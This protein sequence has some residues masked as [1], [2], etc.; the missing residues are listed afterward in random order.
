MPVCLACST[1]MFPGVCLKAP[2][3][4]LPSRAGF[5][6]LS[7]GLFQEH[8]L[9]YHLLH[10]RFPSG[11]CFPRNSACSV[12]L[13]LHISF[14]LSVPQQ[15]PWNRWSLIAA[16]S[17][18]NHVYSVPAWTFHG[19]G[20]VWS[21]NHHSNNPGIKSHFPT[22]TPPSSVEV[23]TPRDLAAPTLTQGLGFGDSRQFLGQS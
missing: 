10:A 18:G 22:P 23:K 12:H 3:L 5:P 11:F 15:N 7:Q 8:S 4:P 6:S 13:E 21:P 9:N 19:A 17:L 2:S 16:L 20:G 1:V 14:W